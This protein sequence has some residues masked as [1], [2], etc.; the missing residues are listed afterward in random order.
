LIAKDIKTFSYKEFHIKFYKIFNSKKF[1]KL[2]ISLKY[3]FTQ[4]SF[5]YL[6]L[7]HLVK[8]KNFYLKNNSSYPLDLLRTNIYNNIYHLDLGTQSGNTGVHTRNIYL[9]KFF[10]KK[11]LNLNIFKNNENYENINKFKFR[12]SKFYKSISRFYKF[13]KFSVDLMKLM[14]ELK[15]IKD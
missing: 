3:F 1:Q 5:R 9:R 15:K 6:I 7:S 11:Y 10:K 4:I 12:Y 2:P 14:D 13:K 8:F